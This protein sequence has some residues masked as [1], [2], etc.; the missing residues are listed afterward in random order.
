MWK[1][2]LL[3][4]LV[5]LATACA[6]VSAAYAPVAHAP[7]VV[8]HTERANLPQVI[9]QAA[10]PP[11]AADPR[12]AHL[13]F[14]MSIAPALVP[15]FNE[16]AGDADV[17]RADHVTLVDLLE[18]V[19]NGKRLVIFKNAADAEALVPRLADKMD[20]I[21]YNL[22][23]GPANRPDEQADPVAGI[24]RVRA[25]ADQHGMQ[26]AMGPDR[27]FALSHG[28]ALAPYA[29]LFVLQVQRVQTEPETVR[30][31]VVPLVKEL[32]RANPE[33]Q[34][35]IQ[36]RT[37]GDVDALVELV[38]SLSESIDGVSILSTE[39]T[40]PFAAELLAA[41]RPLRDESAPPAPAQTAPAG[42]PPSVIVET[43]SPR[44]TPGATPA[45]PAGGPQGAAPPARVLLLWTGL[46]ALGVL[47]TG[48]A[49]TAVIYF[50][51]HKRGR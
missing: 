22:E 11:R 13:W 24:R 30:D 36:I 7:V 16:Y 27:N 37:E 18:R 23:H 49:T 12:L 6:P 26:V 33:L 2:V 20:I 17:A 5:C 40:A 1:L 21:G 25:L 44:R 48:V 39:E 50:T 45:F 3:S 34:V 42:L 35:S 28:V 41:L 8:A 9:A 51:N 31:F 15:I 32:R 47:L 43:P 10:T 29:D 19:E 4:G 14:D 38:A 46:A